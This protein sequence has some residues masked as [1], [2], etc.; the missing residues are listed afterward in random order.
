[1]FELKGKNNVAK[2]FTDLCDEKTIG[3]VIGLLNSPVADNSKIRIMPDCHS[4]AGCVIGTTMTIKDKICPNLVGVDI[5]CGMLCISLDD[6]I[7]F[8]NI[9]NL[10]K[11]DQ[12]C[13]NDIPSGFDVHNEIPVKLW[14]GTIF[15]FKNDWYM[16][17]E[18]M[19]DNLK[20]KDK[21]SNKEHLYKSLGSLGGGNHFIEIN[22]DDD[23]NYY[24]VIHSGSRNLGT[25]VASIYQK[26]AE[27]KLVNNYEAKKNLIEQLKKEGRQSEIQQKLSE[28]QNEQPK[29]PKE[30]AYLTGSDLEDYLHDLYICQE[31]ASN[32]RK[33]MAKIMLSNFFEFL[34]KEKPAVS[35]EDE[36]EI[37]CEN[38]SFDIRFNYFETIHNYISPEELI[39]RKGAISAKNNEM[40]LIPMNMRD[41]SLICIGLGNEDWNYS[42]PHGAGRLM[43]RGQAKDSISIEDFENSMKG[44]Y[45]TSVNQSTI[46]ESPFAYKP[47]DSIINNIKDTVKIIKRIVPVY[48]FKA[49]SD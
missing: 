19:I 22:K 30:L 39:L 36:F 16:P 12:I 34:Y 45:T 41:G 40:V 29:F 15:S 18:G 8:S 4:G 6:K 23:G 47:M 7:D 31:F 1:M 14:K 32:S 35:F 25:Q 9:K 2:V 26:I 10:E 33:A 17:W 28:L 43:S 38:S 44:I 3:Q 13:H 27:E 46:D 48:N 21:L 20:C 42:A 24:L 37:S 11:F 5:G 49:S